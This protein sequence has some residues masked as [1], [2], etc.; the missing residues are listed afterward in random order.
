MYDSAWLA[1]H[2]LLLACLIRCRTLSISI[3][4]TMQACHFRKI[5]TVR[6]F[7]LVL[8]STYISQAPT[9]VTWEVDYEAFP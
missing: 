5:A 1:G 9:L 6:H 4:A 7:R 8:S 2:R 3:T